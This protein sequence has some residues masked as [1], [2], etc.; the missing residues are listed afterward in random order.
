MLPGELR[1]RQCGKVYGAD[2]HCPR[3]HNT[4]AVRRAAG[5]GYRCLACNAPRE[6]GPATIVSEGDALV[7]GGAD[8]ARRVAPGLL[9]A[10]GVVSMGGG[11]LIS[12]AL[13]AIVGGVAGGA[14]AVASLATGVGVGALLLRGGR[15]WGDDAAGRDRAERELA[16]LELAAK[17]GGSLTVT[18]AAMGLGLASAD[19]EAALD[20][21]ADGSRV[22]AE[23]TADGRIEY[24]FRELVAAR[25][26]KVR[27]EIEPASE[28]AEERELARDGRREGRGD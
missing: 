18:E 1:C 21:M 9:R 25:G 16:I 28:V 3:C 11:L 4:A 2:N 19:A 10:L 27:V 8:V 14:L 12:A 15:R 6:L 22:S 5:G 24:V 20:A 7:S 17:Q 13:L 26:P 23:V